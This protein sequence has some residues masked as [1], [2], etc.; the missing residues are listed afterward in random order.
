MTAVVTTPARRI[1]PAIVV[2]TVLAAVLFGL[3]WV[4]GKVSIPLGWMFA[5]VRV[6][7]TDARR[8]GAD[9]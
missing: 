8:V 6:G 2:L 7:W 9:S 3:G 1:T 4:V 5:A